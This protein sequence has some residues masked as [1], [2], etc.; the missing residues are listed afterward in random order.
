MGE[1]DLLEFETIGEYNGLIRV[2]HQKAGGVGFGLI[3]SSNAILN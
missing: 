3:M 1:A 2:V